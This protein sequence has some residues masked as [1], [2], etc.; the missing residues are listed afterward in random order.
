MLLAP[1][2]AELA[3][4][5]EPECKWQSWQEGG[6]LPLEIFPPFIDLSFHSFF[7]QVILGSPNLIWK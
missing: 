5:E 6:H 7:P 2:P 4:S 3:P 1:Q